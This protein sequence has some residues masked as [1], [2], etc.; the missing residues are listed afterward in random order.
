MKIII[1]EIKGSF[2]FQNGFIHALKRENPACICIWNTLFLWKAISINPIFSNSCFTASL[3]LPLLFLDST[4]VKSLVHMIQVVVSNDRH[5]K[6]QLLTKIPTPACGDW[7]TG[8]W[9]QPQTPARIS[10]G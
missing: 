4:Q 2:L 9:D 1:F 6:A 5:P 7:A 10:K 3:T 8:H